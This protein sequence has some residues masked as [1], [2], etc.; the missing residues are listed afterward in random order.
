[1]S[2]K[3]SGRGS[4]Q[5]RGGLGGRGG[6]G[7]GRSTIGYSYYGDTLK[8]KGLCSALGIYI[9]QHD[10]KASVFQMSP[11]QEKRLHHVG[12]IYRHEISNKLFNKNTVTIAKS[13]HT[14]YA[15]DK[16]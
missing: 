6:W 13:E 14:Q 2:G 3:G 5:G 11:T 8:H 16:H 1:M 9:V 12:T 15:L 4:Y 10:Q 7:R